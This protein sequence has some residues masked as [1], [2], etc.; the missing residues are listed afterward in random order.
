[1]SYK[2]EITAA[3]TAEL[4]GKL[5]ALATSMVPNNI[6]P[7]TVA[8]PV[9]PEVKDAAKPTRSRK[10]KA[11][12]AA[13]TATGSTTAPEDAPQPTAQPEIVPADEPETEN[14]V[15]ADP[16][17]EAA[18][19]DFDKDVTPVVL[20]AVAAK[21][22]PWVQEILSQFGVERASQ[23][24]DAQFGELIAAIEGGL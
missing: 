10:A 19:L 8:D 1:M 2:I 17:P 12:D 22:K 16:Q 14:V 11:D 24:P 5:M 4:A 3:S 7:S 13:S 23:I 15:V 6:M 18:A 20:K 21:G 9:M